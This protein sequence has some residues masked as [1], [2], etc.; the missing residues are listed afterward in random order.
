MKSFLRPKALRRGEVIGLV[1]PAGALWRPDRVEGCVRYLEGQGYRVEV[2][3]H[4]LGN[5]GAFSGT[6]DERLCDL[7]GM[8]RDPRI[9]AILALRGGYGT[10]RL[11]DRIDY[12]AVRRDPK[13]VVGYSDIT[14]LQMAL[15]RKTGLVSF[16]GPLGAVE[17][18]SAPDPVTEESFWRLVT[19]RRT[20]G[21]LPLP[22]D[23]PLVTRQKG[24]GEGPLLGGCLSLVVALLGTPFSPDYRGAVVALEDVHEQFHRIDRM[25]TQLRLAGVL[26][27][28]TGLL[29]GRFTHTTAADLAHPFH[30]LE[31]IWRSVLHGVQA[32]ILEGFPYGHVPR[33]VTLPWGIPVRVDGKKQ[34]VSLLESAVV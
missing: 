13:I 9:R 29:L 17:F 7:N 23:E 16:S 5:D 15:Y 3:A 20:R 21:R 24:L 34:A 12:A 30:D 10:P 18:A 26:G 6:D 1:A 4:A 11:L 28:A 8:L 31:A 27:R 14:A 2:G 32:P 19:S 22:D 33:K 25:I